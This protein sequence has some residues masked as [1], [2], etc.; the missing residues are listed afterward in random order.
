MS[1]TLS[2]FA[3]ISEC[4]RAP[5]QGQAYLWSQGSEGDSFFFFGSADGYAPGSYEVRLFLGNT[6]VSRFPFVIEPSRS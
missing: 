4:T 2:H 5:V 3:P 6:E 1:T